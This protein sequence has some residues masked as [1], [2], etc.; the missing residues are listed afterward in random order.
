[1]NKVKGIKSNDFEEFTNLIND[2]SSKNEVFATQTHIDT[3]DKHQNVFYAFIWYKSE[4]TE[5]TSPGPQKQEFK[6][7]PASTAQVNALR[8]V[9]S[10]EDGKEFLK[11]IGFNGEFGLLT[12][13]SAFELI[14]KVKTK[15]EQEVY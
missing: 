3:S 11:T 1:M 13:K 5:K 14:S 7:K 6:G 9:W 12:G 15:Q 2:F 10:T 8:R 4:S